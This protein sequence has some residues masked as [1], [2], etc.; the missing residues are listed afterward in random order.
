MMAK[1]GDS[2]RELVGTVAAALDSESTV[3]TEQWIEGP[4]FADAIGRH[5]PFQRAHVRF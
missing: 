3:K 5:L 4:D 1:A 2:Y